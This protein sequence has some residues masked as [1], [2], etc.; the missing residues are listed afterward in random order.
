MKLQASSK[1]PETKKKKKKQKSPPKFNYKSSSNPSVS[2][3]VIVSKLGELEVL[4]G[5]M[6]RAG[7]ISI[8]ELKY[9]VSFAIAATD[10]KMFS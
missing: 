6:R 1:S 8:Q 9:L 7:A 10:Q 4:R 5:E 2:P 3:S